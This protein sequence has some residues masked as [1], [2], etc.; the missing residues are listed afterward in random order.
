MMGAKKDP[1]D[2]SRCKYSTVTL[3]K[4]FETQ[5]SRKLYKFFKTIEGQSKLK[6]I[7]MNYLRHI[8][9]GWSII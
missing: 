2:E 8:L 9:E 4:L 3:W 7:R 5:N 6:Y 1:S